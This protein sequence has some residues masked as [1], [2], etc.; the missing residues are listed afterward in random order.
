MPGLRSARVPGGVRLYRPGL[1]AAIL[2]RGFSPGRRE[3]IAAKHEGLYGS[4]LRQP[5]RTP[6][7][8]AAY[9]APAIEPFGALPATSSGS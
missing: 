3:R 2:L 7:E 8:K 4:L 6:V 1:G 5:G 9:D